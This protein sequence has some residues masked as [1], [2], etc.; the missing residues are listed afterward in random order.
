[1]PAFR[2]ASAAM[3]AALLLPGCVAKTALDVATLPVKAG[4]KAAD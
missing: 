1:M 3:A 4:A 2:T